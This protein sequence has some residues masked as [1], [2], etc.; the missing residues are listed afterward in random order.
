MK[1]TIRGGRLIDPA[2]QQDQVTDIH[3]D[4][5]RILALGQ[6]PAGFTPERTLHA[7][8]QVIAP[9]LIDIGTHLREPGPSYK[10]TLRSETKAALAGGYTTL[11]CRPDTSPC[12][13]S[14]AVVQQIMDKVELIGQAKVRPIGAMTK[15]LEGTH[16][17]NMAGLQHSGCVAVSNMRNAIDNTLILR[18]CFEY[19]STFD[20]RVVFYPEDSWLRA[21][22]C[23]HEGALASRLGL[24]GIPAAA[25]AIGLSRVL[26][27]VAVT[28][29]RI[30]FSALSTAQAVEMIAKAQAKGLPVTA[31]TTMAHLTYTEAEIDGYNSQFFVQPPLRSESDREALRQGVRDGVLSVI[32]SA[33]LPHEE[34]AKMAPFAAS[35]PG[36]ATLETLLSQGLELV[37]SGVFSL[38]QLIERLTSGPAEAMGLNAGQLTEGQWADLIVFD[39]EVSWQVK[40][41]DLFTAGEN[42]PLTGSTL[43]GQV[44]IALVNGQIAFE[45]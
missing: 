34:A 36:M 6:A 14:S 3:I 18:R 42:S 35:E 25:E 37:E 29:V 32:S 9:G 7:E 4:D 16:L 23:A 15:N 21:D 1:I 2:Q 30:H 33:H 20:L 40:D 13:D 12:I 24:A 11:C 17:S 22:G 41:S 44:Q 31:D 39:P 28:G 45:R 38:P 10:G 27:L 43:K 19:A 5:G 26:H 8:G